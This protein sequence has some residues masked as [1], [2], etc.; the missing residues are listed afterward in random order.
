MLEDIE[1]QQEAIGYRQP[2]AVD[3]QR[4]GES[5]YRRGLFFWLQ[6]AIRASPCV[7]FDVSLDI[8]G[9]LV[10]S[11]RVLGNGR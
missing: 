2:A 5:L 9:L 4:G 6:R 8:L 10:S 1:K 11:A 7:Q 3:K